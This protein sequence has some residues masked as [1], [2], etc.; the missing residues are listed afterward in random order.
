MV[1][2]IT[3]KQQNNPSL[4][5]FSLSLNCERYMKLCIYIYTKLIM[6]K[7]KY[8]N[9]IVTKHILNTFIVIYHFFRLNNIFL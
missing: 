7:Q 8:N 2:A 6:Y 5:I 9:F 1:Y 4:F 3:G